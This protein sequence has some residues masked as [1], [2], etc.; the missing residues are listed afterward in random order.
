[1]RL[2]LAGATLVPLLAAMA[3]ATDA[4]F[5]GVLT[6][7]ERTTLRALIA[8]MAKRHGPTG[9]PVDGSERTLSDERTAAWPSRRS[10]AC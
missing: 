3:D 10:W 7:D 9:T 6:E 2:T 1:M 4:A 8:K 5:F